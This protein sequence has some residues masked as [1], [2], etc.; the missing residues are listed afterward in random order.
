MIFQDLA[1]FIVGCCVGAF[2]LSGLFIVVIVSMHS[3]S[4]SRK[5]ENATE[6]D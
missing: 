1:R 3:S 2:I 5:E 4:I 6:L